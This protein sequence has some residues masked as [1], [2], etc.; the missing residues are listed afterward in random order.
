[1]ALHQRDTTRKTPDRRPTNLLVAHMTQG[2]GAIAP[3]RVA[4]SQRIT[5]PL[6]ALG[7][8][9]SRRW[10]LLISVVLGLTLAGAV[11]TPIF[12]AV[13]WTAL[14]TWIFTSYHFICAQVPSHSYYLLGYQLALCARNLAIYGSL[15]AGTLAFQTV[16]RWLPALDWRVWLLTL[17]PMG[18]DGGMQLFGWWESNWELRMLT[19]AI[20]GLGICW[21]L[22][23][24]LEATTQGRDAPEVWPQLPARMSAWTTP[25]R[26]LVARAT[27]A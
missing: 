3:W 9:L 16:R 23:P 11:A 18:L 21:L 24:W 25:L 17:V 12:Y 26:G 13:G 5:R 19:G 6:D 15:F 7:A 10:L 8:W 14:G 20:F 4:L 27:R 22:L 1:M 2:S